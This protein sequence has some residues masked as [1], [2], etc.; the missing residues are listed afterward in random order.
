MSSSDL[1]TRPRV[2][3][4]TNAGATP[5]AP[6]SEAGMPRAESISPA[7][8]SG[9]STPFGCQSVLSFSKSR[10][11][12]L[13]DKSRQV[14]FLADPKSDYPHSAD[15]GGTATGFNSAATST[16]ALPPPSSTQDLNP[17]P[18]DEP[19]YSSFPN[20]WKNSILFF[21]TMTAFLSPLTSNIYMSAIPSVARDLQQSQEAIQLTVTVFMIA[22]GISPMIIGS[23]TDKTG[24]K[25]IYI[26]SLVIYLGA[27]IGVY[28]LPSATPSSKGSIYAGLMVLRALQAC[29]SASVMS[30]GQGTVADMYP[31]STRAGPLGIFVSS[32]SVGP[33]IG[34]LLG[35]AI[36]SGAGWRSIFL[37]CFCLAAF[38]MIML[39]TFLPET[40]RKLVGNGSQPA[41]TLAHEALFSLA[42]R[43]TV[44]QRT[45]EP[46]PGLPLPCDPALLEGMGKH[47]RRWTIFYLEAKDMLSFTPLRFL[48]IPEVVLCLLG[49]AFPFSAQMMILSTIAKNFEQHYGFTV[50]QSGLVFLST[51]CG[52]MTAAFVSG[53]TLNWN[54]RRI[55]RNVT[56]KLEQEDAEA[57]QNSLGNSQNGSAPFTTEGEGKQLDREKQA[58]LSTA[59]STAQLPVP[60][61]SSATARRKPVGTDGAKD[62][63]FPLENARL[64][65]WPYMMFINFVATLAYGWCIGRTHCAAPIIFLFLNGFTVGTFNS[66]FNTTMLDYLPS[67]SAGVS[68]ASNFVRCLLGAAGTACIEYIIKALGTGGTYTIVAGISALSVPCVIAIK[69]CGPGWRAKRFAAENS[70]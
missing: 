31:S 67:R 39:L 21:I 66:I 52:A 9:A 63:A 14:S 43:R 2:T 68:A 6:P 33:A 42:T 47:K 20:V 26:V 57:H 25:P 37:F 30:I 49:Y 44:T 69:I 17:D 38:C 35:A 19:P 58:T 27:C 54:Y 18:Q 23:N 45:G 4:Q 60:T 41:P 32:I 61:L 65:V 51:G 12:S 56:A 7:I 24:R 34:P 22:Q 8:G 11:P 36:T 15:K 70:A 28:R 48:L 55:S 64:M 5:E 46:R 59:A 29:G 62:P 1:G 50:M 40:L 10:R 16:T 53:R 3:I 13:D